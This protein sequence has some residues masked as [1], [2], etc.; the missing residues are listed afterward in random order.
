[1]VV[2]W[3]PLLGT[4][5]GI[6]Y[7]LANTLSISRTALDQTH[8]I[9]YVADFRFGTK[10]NPEQGTLDSQN[11]DDRT[12]WLQ[13]PRPRPFYST[14]VRIVDGNNLLADQINYLKRIHYPTVSDPV[15]VAY[16]EFNFNQWNFYKIPDTASIPYGRIFFP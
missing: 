13:D 14:H 8:V 7:A 10:D 6:N 4:L 15:I 1:M 11:Q 9:P 12:G 16:Q 5:Q 3:G 2:G